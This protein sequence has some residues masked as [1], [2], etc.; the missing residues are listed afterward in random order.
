MALTGAGRQGDLGGESESVPCIG[1]HVPHAKRAIAQVLPSSPVK[2]LTSRGVAR[3]SSRAL[4]VRKANNAF[5]STASLA[6]ATLPTAVAAPRALPKPP[7]A[8]SSQAG[9]SHTHT[10]SRRRSSDLF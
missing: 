8:Q 1:S 2:M 10:T 9:A 3:L 4:K 6:R 5:L 7:R